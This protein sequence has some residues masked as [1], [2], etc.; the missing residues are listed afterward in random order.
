MNWYKT[1][2]NWQETINYL[3]EKE[4]EMEKSELVP[5]NES[6]RQ[7]YEILRDMGLRYG[8]IFEIREAIHYISSRASNPKYFL[9][10]I[11]KNPDKFS[12]LSQMSDLGLKKIWNSIYTFHWTV[13]NEL[14]PILEHNLE[15]G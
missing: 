11:R 3:I 10:V 8:E 13:W 6:T 7:L 5:S 2:Q 1:A 14:I 15:I 9:N 4:R 12:R